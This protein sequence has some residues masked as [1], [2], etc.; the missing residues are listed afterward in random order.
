V[1]PCIAVDLC[2]MENMKNSWLGTVRS[3]TRVHRYTD[4]HPTPV[5]VSAGGSLEGYY[6]VRA[7]DAGASLAYEVKVGG[8]YA[9]TASVAFEPQDGACPI[10]S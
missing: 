1:I 8:G 7:E 6:P 3:L 4:G 2:V 10:H 9:V 5:S